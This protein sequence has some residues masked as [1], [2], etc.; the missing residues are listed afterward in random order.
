MTKN[1]ATGHLTDDAGLDHVPVALVRAVLTLEVP[2]GAVSRELKCP[3]IKT[4][5]GSRKLKC[6]TIK[7]GSV[8]RKLKCPT[9]KTGSVNSKLKCPTIKT[10]PSAV[11]RDV[12]QSQ[13][14][15]HS[16]SKKKFNH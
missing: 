9:I 4:G 12:Q 15:F 3:T 1:S 6:P 14:L 10:G 16:M 11:N 13:K 7:T 8:S 2:A 5:S